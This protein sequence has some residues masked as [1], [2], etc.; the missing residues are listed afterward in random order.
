MISGVLLKLFK[1]YLLMIRVFCFGLAILMTVE[2]IIIPE[3][4]MLLI[5]CLMIVGAMFLVPTIPIGIA[6]ANEVSYPMDET[7]S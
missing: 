2:L 3:R 7:V 1:K 6:F 4:K 5:A